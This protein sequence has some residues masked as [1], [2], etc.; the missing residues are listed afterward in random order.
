M[1]HLP[2]LTFGRNESETFGNERLIKSSEFRKGLLSCRPE[3]TAPH[4]QAWAG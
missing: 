2:E 4:A 1:V 3:L